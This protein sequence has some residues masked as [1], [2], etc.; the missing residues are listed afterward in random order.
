MEPYMSVQKLA[1]LVG[2]D[3]N[4]GFGVPSKAKE[5]SKKKCIDCKKPSTRWHKKNRGDI[6]ADLCNACYQRKL[7]Y[8]KAKKALEKV[9]E[10]ER[11][12]SAKTPIQPPPFAPQEKEKH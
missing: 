4:P 3:T 12:S 8:E 7:R 10:E 5:I 6:T 2:Y 11:P 1:G 9:D